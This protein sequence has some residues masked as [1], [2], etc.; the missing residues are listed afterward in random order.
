MKIYI[1]HS[2]GYGIPKTCWKRDSPKR[3]CLTIMNYTLLQLRYVRQVS[4]LRIVQWDSSRD[5]SPPFGKIYVWNLLK[6][7]QTSKSKIVSSQN[8]PK[9]IERTNCNGMYNN[10]IVAHL[11]AMIPTCH[12][13]CH[14]E[15][16][17]PLDR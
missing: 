7:H 13:L 8:I 9:S 14:A 16:S 3:F 5:H 12:D 6:E 4:F 15:T 10:W 11:V 1:S 2:M 17:L